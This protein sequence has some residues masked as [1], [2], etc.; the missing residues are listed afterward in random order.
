MRQ[1][2]DYLMFA[3]FNDLMRM[4]N[5]RGAPTATEIPLDTFGNVHMGDADAQTDEK[6]V[7]V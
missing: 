1:D 7:S 3:K 4:D 2:V 5:D 6:L